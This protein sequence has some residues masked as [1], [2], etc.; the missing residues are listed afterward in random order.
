M[1]TCNA[2]NEV[3]VNRYLRKEIRFSQVPEIISHVMA[4]HSVSDAS[5]LEKIQA[6][7]AWAR[8]KAQHYE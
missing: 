1:V 8:E 3:A 7:D 6:A 2:A 5:S 4:E